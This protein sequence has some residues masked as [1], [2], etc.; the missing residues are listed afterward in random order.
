MFVTKLID[1]L[2]Q[3]YKIK[4]EY[5]ILKCFVVAYNVCSSCLFTVDCAP[6]SWPFPRAPTP[7][8]SPLTLNYVHRVSV[9][10]HQLHYI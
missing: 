1:F 4:M 2:G 7:A 6:V 10:T 3:K 9:S 8:P 5:F